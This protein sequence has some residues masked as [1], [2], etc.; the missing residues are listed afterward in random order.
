MEKTGNTI[1]TND[2]K[3]ALRTLCRRSCNAMHGIAS[4]MEQVVEMKENCGKAGEYL[5][6]RTPEECDKIM[7]SLV[8]ILRCEANC[9]VS[10][11]GAVADG[12]EVEL[13]EYDWGE[14][15]GS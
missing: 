4:L 2:P 3:L 10:E 5:S 1:R 14:K 13:P 6:A 8:Y 9:G 7:K 15:H 11:A 12:Y